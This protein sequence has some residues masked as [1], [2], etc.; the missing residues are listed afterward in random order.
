[1]QLIIKR[2]LLKYKRTNVR[3]PHDL[4]NKQV[5]G[6]WAMCSFL[7]E[8]WDTKNVEEGGKQHEVYSDLVLLGTQDTLNLQPLLLV[9]VINITKQ[10]ALLPPLLAIMRKSISWCCMYICYSCVYVFNL[11]FHRHRMSSKPSIS[12][13]RR[14]HSC[15]G[16][17]QCKENWFI[18]KLVCGDAMPL[19][20][21]LRTKWVL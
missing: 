5:T 1:M 21:W 9:N 2:H 16:R 4:E 10:R 11:C 13:L 15:M 3:D 17:L 8:I 18:V 12:Y 19:F 6:R 7:L 20:S 14:V